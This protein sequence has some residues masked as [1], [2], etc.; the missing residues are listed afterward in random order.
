[1]SVTQTFWL[2]A[3][4]VDLAASDDGGSG[5]PPLLAALRIGGGTKGNLLIDIVREQPASGAAH[6]AILLA[7]TAD[8][9]N[10][11]RPGQGAEAR[12]LFGFTD[13]VDWCDGLCRQGF[14]L[15]TATIAFDEKTKTLTVF[16]P[17]PSGPKAGP[18]LEISGVDFDVGQTDADVTITYTQHL[19]SPELGTSDVDLLTVAAAP[20]PSK[21]QYVRPSKGGSVEASSTALFNLAP[22][23]ARLTFGRSLSGRIDPALQVIVPVTA[24]GLRGVPPAPTAFERFRR[25]ASLLATGY[26]FEDVEL[27]GFRIDLGRFGTVADNVL[28]AMIAPLNFHLL[29][30]ITTHVGGSYGGQDFKFRPAARAVVIELL[31]YGKMYWGDA[32]R[33]VSP[34]PFTSQH[35]L[36]MRVL[37]GRVDDDSTQAREPALYV[38]AIFVDNPWSKLIG[39]EFQGF[40]K[41]LVNF[42][43]HDGTALTMD[44]YGNTPGDRRRVPLSHVAAVRPVEKVGGRSE[45]GP[46]VTFDYPSSLDESDAWLENA[47]STESVVSSVLVGSRWRQVDFTE[48][49]FRRSFARDVFESGFTAFS[50]IQ[51]APVD[52]RHLPGAWITGKFTLSKARAAYPPGVARL[53]LGSPRFG[54]PD[55][56]S[57]LGSLFKG[58][59]IALPSGEWYRARCNINMQIDDG[60]V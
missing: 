37:V 21:R 24:P 25:P 56:W 26:R 17:L 23:G 48:E 19:F 12:C 52:E 54:T 2:G 9:A 33:G 51:V 6:F 49:E 31:R 58:E 36:L 60:L 45:V 40:D 59:E 35:E 39:R 38:P 1:M 55:A 27:F 3:L 34:E 15:V 5:F 30:G 13:R 20:F 28:Q 18:L 43:T 41:R 22:L 14:T 11:D 10:I 42:E 46:L 16:D 29:P 47:T 7:T 32:P 53:T 57:M 4:D 8:A 50:S 44:G